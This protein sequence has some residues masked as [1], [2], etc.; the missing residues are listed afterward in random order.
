[1]RASN[2]SPIIADEKT[3]QEKTMLVHKLRTIVLVAAVL[4]MSLGLGG[5]RKEKTPT[6]TPTSAVKSAPGK[7]LLP[8][9]SQGK[10]VIPTPSPFVSPT[11]KP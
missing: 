3:F 8:G 10:S 1:V 9:S 2:T 7:Q 6:P 11:K 4:A 5:C